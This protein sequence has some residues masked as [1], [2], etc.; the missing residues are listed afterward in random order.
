[1]FSS[2]GISSQGSILASIPFTKFSHTT[3]SLEAVKF[4]WNHIGRSDLDFVV[5]KSRIALGDGS[6]GSQTIMKVTA[7]ADILEEQ[8]L[9]SLVHC[10]QGYN[11]SKVSEC[12]VQLVVK[13]PFMAMRY[14]KDTHTVRRIQLKFRSDADFT[15]A[16][17]CLTSVGLHVTQSPPP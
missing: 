8:N 10:L 16:L 7:G 15:V 11:A 3:N 14:P 2:Q 4:T 6:H 13:S 1:M 17:D 12:P 9:D 5:H